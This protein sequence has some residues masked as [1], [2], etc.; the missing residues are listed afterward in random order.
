MKRAGCLVALVVVLLIGALGFL[1]F[2]G[3]GE[4]S[5]QAEVIVK[6]YYEA[7]QQRDFDRALSYCSPFFFERTSREETTKFLTAVNT[8]LGALVSYDR[9]S[10]R[11]TQQVGQQLG[12]GT[13]VT[14]LYRVK[15]DKGEAEETIVLFRPINEATSRIVGYNVSS[16]ALLNQ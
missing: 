13:L 16:T 15:Y 1:L 6:G 8:K 12:S 14:L 3:A 5:A 10:W 2:R 9:V 7:I 4:D 11:A